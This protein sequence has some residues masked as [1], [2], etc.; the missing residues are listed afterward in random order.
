MEKIVIGDR[1]E[2]PFVLLL[3]VTQSCG[4]PLPISGFTGKAMA[5]MLNDIAVVIPREVTVLTEQD[6][7]M[8]LEEETSLMEVLR[9]VHGI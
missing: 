3:K 5:Q 4:K 9:A 2:H 6:M 8:E 1:N 7:V